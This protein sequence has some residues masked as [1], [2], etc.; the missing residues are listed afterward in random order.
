[1]DVLECKHSDEADVLLTRNVHQL[2]VKIFLTKNVHRTEL[3][4]RLKYYI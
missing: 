3:V 4:D 1:M 2:I